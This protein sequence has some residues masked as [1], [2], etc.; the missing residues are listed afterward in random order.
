MRRTNYW[1]ITKLSIFL[2]LL[3]SNIVYASPAVL[4]S[5]RDS[6]Q[7]LPIDKYTNKYDEHFIKYTKQY[8]G[9][10]F[11]WKWFKAQTCAESAFKETAKSPVGAAGLMQIMPGTFREITAKT[12]IPNEPFTA[13]WAISGGIYYDSTLYRQWKSP[14]PEVDRIA[15]TMGSYNCGIGN[16]LKGQKM[17]TA[18]GNTNCNTWAGVKKAAPKVKSWKYEET[19]G[20]VAR[21]TKLMGISGF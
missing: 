16:V 14:R 18:D 11:N 6:F 8:F 21:I 12:G 1:T 19:V 5:F 7:V 13:K 2:L 3:F 4:P 10:G 9:I 15:L 20:Y 17:C